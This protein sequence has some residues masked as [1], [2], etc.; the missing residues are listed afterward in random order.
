MGP[1]G[2][3]IPA[4]PCRVDYVALIVVL[5]V[6]SV[7]RVAY[8]YW[9]HETDAQVASIHPLT[10]SRTLR[11]HMDIASTRAA[12][13]SVSALLPMFESTSLPASDILAGG[14][15][16]GSALLT[17]GDRSRDPD[18]YVTARAAAAA[19]SLL[20]MPQ[21][22]HGQLSA[23]QV[24]SALQQSQFGVSQNAGSS[25]STQVQDAT[26][27]L[28][29]VW[30]DSD[31]SSTSLVPNSNNAAFRATQFMSAM[32]MEQA[33]TAAVVQ[34]TL[35][36]WSQGG[37]SS[38][39][40]SGRNLGTGGL[41]MSG[42]S[43]KPSM[44]PSARPQGNPG[45]K[46]KPP[47]SRD[48]DETGEGDDGDDD[49]PGGADSARKYCE[50]PPPGTAAKGSSSSGKPLPSARGLPHA[51]FPVASMFAKD[52]DSSRFTSRRYKS[53]ALVGSSATLLQAR[54]GPAIDSHDAVIRYN[55]APTTGDNDKDLA[56]FVGARTT[57]RMVNRGWISQ[58]ST[59]R[60]LGP[61]MGAARGLAVAR[62]MLACG[63]EDCPLEEGVVLLMSRCYPDLHT[64]IQNYLRA[65]HAARRVS[66]VC[67]KPATW[68]KA[69][70]LLHAYR[71]RLACAGGTYY[72][73]AQPTSGYISSWIMAKMCD[74]VTIYGFGGGNM[75]YFRAL[76][77]RSMYGGHALDLEHTLMR[78]LE[79][80]SSPSQ[81]GRP[82][83]MRGFTLGTINPGGTG[84]TGLGP[85]RFTICEYQEGDEEYNRNCGA[86]K[87]IPAQGVTSGVGNMGTAFGSRRAGMRG[88][89]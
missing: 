42:F 8:F 64:R 40:L 22:V 38:S 7:A 1:Q 11:Q 37:S 20:N 88:L 9:V 62:G 21:Q 13:E 26:A 80:Y 78:S 51:D 43:N 19:G 73:H 30:G 71:D 12:A 18:V 60:S 74:A 63:T 32:G 45:R 14:S 39:S 81:A 70:T 65:A 41:G 46:S 24:E 4:S 69:R 23:Q 44:Q 86:Q 5:V 66:L 75:R 72:G 58:Y 47:A 16:A 27:L 6:V 28:D 2:G 10:E 48:D 59:A 31:S 15:V 29:A 87:P 68:L 53:C 54:F 67:M 83:G 56:P 33:T 50:D 76:N 55:S 25:P 34:P 36:A 52:D 89:S 35:Q 79:H 3:N 77:R 61:V 82:A 49:A 84:G 85:A 57:V 17:R